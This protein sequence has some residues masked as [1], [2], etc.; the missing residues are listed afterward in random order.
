[1]ADILLMAFHKC[2]FFQEINLIIIQFH[3]SLLL[4]G[5]IYS[6]CWINVNQHVDYHV[7]SFGHY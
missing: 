5:Q 6:S 2:I 1:M 7:E 3:Q 4:F